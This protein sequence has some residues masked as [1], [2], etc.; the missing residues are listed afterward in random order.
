[1]LFDEQVETRYVVDFFWLLNIVVLPNILD[2]H[3]TSDFDIVIDKL[4]LT[5]LFI[6]SV[7][8][9]DRWCKNLKLLE[10]G[11][12]RVRLI[13]TSLRRLYRD[14]RRV[15]ED[16]SKIHLIVIEGHLVGLQYSYQMLKASVH[17]ILDRVIANRVSGKCT[18]RK[19]GVWYVLSPNLLFHK[20]Q[21]EAHG[22]GLLVVLAD[23]R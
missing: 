19:F 20:D 5:T 22:I 6:V 9:V 21:A 15:L 12:S 23:Q 2:G 10:T 8:I 3:C 14:L 7:L 1:V 4:D 17:M 13:D 11:Q 18:P 16:W